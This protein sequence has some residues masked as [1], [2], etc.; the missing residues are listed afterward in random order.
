[1]PEA[2]RLEVLPGL[3][4]EWEIAALMRAA[5]SPNPAAPP[6]WSLRGEVD[7]DQLESLRLVYGAV[8][9]EA[10]AIVVARPAG[11]ESHADDRVAVAFVHPGGTEGAEEALLS[12]EYD[13]GGEMR[14]LGIELWLTD[15]T[16]KRIAA[17]RSGDAQASVADGLSRQVTPLAVRLGGSSGAGLHELLR[18]R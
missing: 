4:V 16:G 14:R 5:D 9:E 13:A 8:A 6:T 18:P 7:W 17:D 15:R 2:L 10:L 11:A 12:T 1:M 3:A